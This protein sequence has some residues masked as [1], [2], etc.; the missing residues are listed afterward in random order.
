[1]DVFDFRDVTTIV[2]I[3]IFAIFGI[4]HL[5]SFLVL[6][7]KIL[8]YYFILILGLALHWS[9][10]FFVTNSFGGDTS[11]IA[12]RASLTTAM[13]TTLGLLLFAKNYLNIDKD[14]HPRLSGTYTVFIWI[15]ICLPFFHI[16]NKMVIGIGW[17]N[18]FFVLLAAITAMASVFLNIFSGFR[19][20]HAHQLNRYYLYS[21]APIL[22]A[23]LLYIGTWFMKRYYDFNANPIVLGTSI[24]VTVQL[25]L[26]SLLIGFKFKAL[27]DEHM[28][29]QLEANIKLKKEVD[30]QTKGLQMAKRE[31]ET[32]NE[33]LEKIGELKNK[34]FSLLAH[35]VRA[36]LN[37]FI[38]IIELIEAEL[39][40]T[41]LKAITGKLKGEIVDKISMVNGL[42]QW[43]YKQLDGVKLDKTIC[44][45]KEVF[46]S[47]KQEFTRM[48]DDKNITIE[49][50]VS[51]PVLFIDENMLKVMLRNLISN[52]IKFSSN[53]QKIIIWSQRNASSVDIGV[54][55]FGMG[56]D[57]HWY[58]KLKDEER[59]QTRK[60]T[61]GE[62]GTGFGLL[63]TKD[64]VE[65]NGGEMIC[66]SEIDHGTNFILRFKDAPENRISNR[67]ASNQATGA[68]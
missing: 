17:L 58:D 39:E 37:N 47:V 66:E 21:Y 26:F 64:F 59:P 63:I 61:K 11:V 8:L 7:H 42:L 9:L 34:L 30:R 24:L 67:T 46:Q 49:L 60:G 62:K 12:D 50:K 6:R 4:Y 57:I 20:F 68:S 36:P 1:M 51:H 32:Q 65:M 45:L 56:M 48:A 38:V 18:D 22:L 23:A 55:D 44:D 5:L 15:V 40:D 29:L 3:S 35:D 27:E 13:I 43:S 52:A 54:Q 33:E 53:G 25:I 16:V 14:H 31:L 10:Y 2:F 41:D 28:T 19:L